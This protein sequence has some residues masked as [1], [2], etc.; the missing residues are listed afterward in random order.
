MLDIRTLP[1]STL[2]TDYL[3]LL[4]EGA[5]EE[6]HAPSATAV[7]VFDH[8]RVRGSTAFNLAGTQIE[9]EVGFDVDAKGQIS[10]V[11]LTASTLEPELDDSLTQAVLRL[12][13]SGLVP[14]PP[15]VSRTGRAYVLLSIRS[16]RG[17]SAIVRPLYREQV[18]LFPL[19][20]D[21]ALLPNHPPIDY[22]ILPAEANVGD[23][24]VVDFVVDE[25]GGVMPATTR[26]I[27][28]HYLNFMR[29]L[30]HGVS[31]FR[32]QPAMIGPC[33]IKM[34]WEYAYVFQTRA[35]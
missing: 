23:S 22:P 26:Y 6:F 8:W 1:D 12:A 7:P 18:Q 24:V 20:Q 17:L 33:P 30:G 25:T 32:F 19:T 34:R 21:L 16:A 13:A 31:R 14:P 4:L 35:K 2:S 10:H 28:G 3:R 27:H 15:A 5:A 11:T 29:A 9:G